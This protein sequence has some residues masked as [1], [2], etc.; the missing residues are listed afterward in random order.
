MS[1]LDPVTPWT[2]L[3]TRVLASN[4]GPMTLDGTNTYAIRHEGS[5]E[6]VIVDPGPLEHD[7]LDRILAQGAVALIL[8]THLHA[9]H[10]AAAATLAA[11]SSAPVRA[12]HP[13]LCI[14]AAPLRH[15]ERIHAAGTVVE[16]LATPGHTADSVCLRLPDDERSG[17]PR[18][19]VL[20]GDTILGRGTTALDSVNGGTLGDYLSTLDLLAA[21]G[22]ETVLPGHGDMRE[23]I[24]D[25]ASEYAAHRARRLEQVRAAVAELA[26]EHPARPLTVEAVTDAVYGRVPP[27]VRAGAEASVAVQLAYLAGGAES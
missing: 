3:A 19:S 10:A 17:I 9:D 6:V 7:H 1:A 15:G 24:A 20:T 25:V 14:D 18:P 8:L 4:P 26:S 2:A 16:V 22:D 13:S 21:L 5:P 12:A 27:G 11:I 23:S